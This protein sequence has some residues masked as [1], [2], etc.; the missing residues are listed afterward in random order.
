MFVFLWSRSWFYLAHTKDY[1]WNYK[2]Q[3]FTF[4][5]ERC[6]VFRRDH[7]VY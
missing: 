5:T 4:K 6:C 7:C 1:F 3:S 2:F